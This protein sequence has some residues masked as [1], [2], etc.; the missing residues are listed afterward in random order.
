M[1]KAGRAFGPLT[2]PY[3]TVPF[4]G[5]GVG[6]VIGV[7]FNIYENKRYTRNLI[8]NGG[9]LPPEARLPLCCIGGVALPVGLFA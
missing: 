6:L 5:I 1:A 7:I 8:K 3:P 2:Y 9:S 4:I